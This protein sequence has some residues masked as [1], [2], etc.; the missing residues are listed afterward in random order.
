M[1]FNTNMSSGYTDSL[2]QR[3]VCCSKAK[4]SSNTCCSKSTPGPLTGQIPSMILLSR[5]CPEP[6]PQEFAKYPKVAIP[7]SILTESKVAPANCSNRINRFSQYQR[8]QAPIPCQPLPQSAN[9]AGI[10]QPSTRQC[11]P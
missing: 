1:S 10:S 6:T 3:S 2:N 5:K 8:Y 9:M 7:S 4:P 11:E